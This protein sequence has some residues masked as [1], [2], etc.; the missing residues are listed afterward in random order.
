MLRTRPFLRLLP[1]LLLPW[2]ALSGSSLVAAAPADR[3]APLLIVGTDDAVVRPILDRLTGVV[4]ASRGVWTTW[5]GTFGRHPVAVARSEGDPLNAVAATVLAIRRHAPALV[6]IVG[7]SRPHDPDLRPGDLV[8]SERFAAFDGMISPV[9]A[10]DA[11]S[12]ALTW[13]KRPHLLL[14]PG[15]RE[16]P[17]EFFPAD[18]AALS[19]A[20]A[21]S[22]A[23][24]RVRR[25]TLGSAHQVNQ[26]ADRVA[27][28]RTHWQ[29]SAEDGESAHIA[30]AAALLGVP[31]IGL[32]VISGTGAQAAAAGL[33]F[34]EASP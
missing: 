5:S 23:P 8:V 22:V 34:L 15:E 27:W 31:A 24:A 4:P 12:D 9:T 32:R 11:G 6:V 2:L 7:V 14:S 20:L 10:L 21:L 28:I 17:T 13:K 29:T 16:T 19:R 18:P 30:G 25:G 3:P 33:A 26:E 1:A